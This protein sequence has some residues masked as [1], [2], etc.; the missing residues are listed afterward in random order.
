MVDTAFRPETIRERMK[1]TLPNG[2]HGHQHSPLNNTISQ[3]GD[4]EWSLLAIGLGDIDPPGRQWLVATREKI[5]PELLQY[6]RQSG[7]QHW[8]VHSINARRTG[9]F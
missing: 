6:I 7:L 1:L 2:L 3:S 4:A 9:A 5:F 8:L